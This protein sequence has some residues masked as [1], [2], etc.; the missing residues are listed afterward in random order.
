[1][2]FQRFSARPTVDLKARTVVVNQG[3]DLD[4]RLDSF[5]ITGPC[6]SRKD[7]RVVL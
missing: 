3:L 5:A 2:R 7:E 1:M 6:W 4:L